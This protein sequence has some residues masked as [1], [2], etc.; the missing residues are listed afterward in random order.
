MISPELLEE[1]TTLWGVYPEKNSVILPALMR[2]QEANKNKLTNEDIQGLSEHL[3]I[4]VGRIRSVATFYSLIHLNKPMGK[5]HLQVDTNISGLLMG[6]GEILNY[7]EEKLGI[8]KGQTTADNLFTLSAVEDLASGGTCPVI[9]V[10]CVLYENMT[11]DK[12]DRLIDSLKKHTMPQN[13][14][15][16]YF[17]TAC[18]VLLKNRNIEN[19]RNIDIY[20]KRGGYKA[21]DKARKMIPDVI[22]TAV[23]DSGIRGRGGAGFP[24][25]VKWGAIPRNSKK[26]I[27]LICKADEGEPGAFKDRQIMEYDPHLLIEGMAIAAHA[28]GAK[29]GFIYIRGELGWIAELLETAIDDAKTDGQLPEFDII[30]HR[31]GGSYV[32]GEETALIE[33]LEGHRGQPRKKPPLPII[34]GLYK[35]PTLV[36]NRKPLR[37]CLLSLNPAR[38]SSKGG[39]LRITMDLNYLRSADTSTNQACMNILWES[40]LWSCSMQPATSTAD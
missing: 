15:V 38:M 23:K 31:G 40:P 11:R 3:H 8:E 4:P 22:V 34:E 20:K 13:E 37:R 7:I 25:G 14:A 9:R 32:C 19:A 24:T 27:Y 6:A 1:I 30:V 33:S 35:C 16:N 28:I 36:N 18:N 39:D 29:L 5:Y 21:L 10:N 17:G 26:P 12:V 2:I